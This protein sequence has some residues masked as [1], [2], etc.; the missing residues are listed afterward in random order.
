MNDVFYRREL[1]LMRRYTALAFDNI[2]RE[3]VAFAAAAAYRVLRL[4]VVRPA[5]D[6]ATTYQFAWGRVV[7]SSALVLSLE[8]FLL[9]LAGVVVAWRRRS[10]L[11][12]LLVPIAYVPATIC[13]VLTN[14]RYTVTVQPLDVCV[15]GA[16]A[17]A[18]FRWDADA[19]R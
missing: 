11:L 12:P 13:F 18:I 2:R 4:F 17:G 10:A 7:Y 9:F 14:Q 15:H 16:G 19:D 8:C 3:P 6:L 1:H 5:G